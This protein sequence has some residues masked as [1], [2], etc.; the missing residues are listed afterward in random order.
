MPRFTLWHSVDTRSLRALWAFKEM[1]LRRGQDYALN[2]LAFPPRQHQPG[3]L[4]HNPLGTVPWFVH[5]EAQDH[6]PRATMSESC[7]IPQCTGFDINSDHVVGMC[8][9]C[10]SPHAPFAMSYLV[11]QK[12]DPCARNSMSTLPKSCLLIYCRYVAELVRSPLAMRLGAD[13]DYPAYL[14]WLAHAD[15]T[16]TFPQ[17]VVMR[18]AIY[19]PGRARNAADDY[20]KW[21][22]ARL[23]L[24]NAALADGRPFLC[25]DRFSL[26]DVCITYALFNASEHGLCGG[27]LLAHGERPLCD[28]YKPQTRE[29]LERMMQRTAWHDA[30]REQSEEG[31]SAGGATV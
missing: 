22:V 3:Y 24:L 4:Q 23:R 28:R 14:N 7:A 31:H 17:A 5:C 10:T 1:G 18:Y 21:F 27:G 29:Y 9:P 12:P 2:I 30:Q 26:A 15:A 20:A 13:P 6:A 25:G 8:Q 11:M 16:L 19:E